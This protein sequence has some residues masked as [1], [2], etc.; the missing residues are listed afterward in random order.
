MFIHD[1]YQKIDYDR[2][3]Q[4]KAVSGVLLVAYNWVLLCIKLQ[5]I[6]NLL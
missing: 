5:F 4:K 1:F 2:Q 6:Y 3:N